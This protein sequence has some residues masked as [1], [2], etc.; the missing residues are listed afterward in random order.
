MKLENAMNEEKVEKPISDAK[1]TRAGNEAWLVSRKKTLLELIV[2]ITSALLYSAAFPP[3]NWS[4]TAW[5]ALAPLFLVVRGLRPRQAFAYG[6]LWGYAHSVSAFFWLREIEPAIPFVLALI[7]AAFPAIWCLLIPVFNR[8]ILIPT[9]IQMR[10]SEAES[11]YRPK[12]WRRIL[13]CAAVAVLWCFLEWIRSWVFTGFPWN[14]AAV[15]QW[16]NLPVIQICEYTGQYGVSFV[17]L[18]LNIALAM[19]VRD[20]RDTI[21]TGKYIRPWP[22]AAGMVLLMAS[23]LTGVSSMLKY[24]VPVGAKRPKSVKTAKLAATVVQGDIAQCRIP[25]PGQAE[26]ALKTYAELTRLAMLNKPD[27]VIWPET[28]VPID[29]RSPGAFGKFYR[30]TVEKLQ[31]ESRIPLMFGTIDFD[32][33]TLPATPLKKLPCHNSVFL[34][35]GNSRIVDKYH[36][37][38]LVPFGEYTPYG[39]YY[40]A[41]KKAFGMGRDLTPGKRITLFN[42]KNG[43]KAGACIC[44]EDVF[45]EI[46]RKLALKGANL[47]IV[48]SNDAWYPTSSEPEQHLA[49]AVMRAVE[50]RLPIIRAGNNS[51]SCL[52]L[53]N[54]FIA[55]SVTTKRNPDGSLSS[56]PVGK[57]RGFATFAIEL[58][59]NP[60]LTFYTRYGDSVFITFCALFL[61]AVFFHIAWGWRWKKQRLLDK[62]PDH[63]VTK[64][65]RPT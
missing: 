60:R 33:E 18:F 37:M 39:E 47:I 57:S 14:F 42:I 48:V 3:L 16:K 9:E 54:G 52:I 65:D 46:T 28:A 7:L 11:N 4:F 41:L 62:F 38:H 30:Y 15:T 12:Q 55:D 21:S 23:V 19:T 45:P 20:I 51:G 36:K 25:K 29:Y 5:F 13:L 44:Y 43:V 53:Q 61:G 58:P 2:I 64:S 35:D 32:Y 26:N 49:N 22:M 27:L 17:I 63:V 6:F 31:R 40:P 56:D 59:V 8:W 24:R 10:G 1:S 50:T 34:L